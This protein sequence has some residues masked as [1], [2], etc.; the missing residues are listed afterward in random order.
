MNKSSSRRLMRLGS[1]ATISILLPVTGW[2][3]ASTDVIALDAFVVNTEADSGYLSSNTLSGNLTNTPLE[4]VPANISVINREFLDDIASDNIFDAVEF[5]TGAHNVDGPPADNNGNSIVFR[6]FQSNWQSR[7]GFQWYVPTDNYNTERVEFNRG[8]VGQLYGESAIAG[9]M[10][11]ETKR[12]LLRDQNS[13]VLR[14]DSEGSRRGSLDLNRKL[15]DNLGVRINLLGSEE[16]FWTSPAS[17]D[18]FG[19]AGA[20]QWRPYEQTRIDI[21]YEQGEINR[22]PIDGRPLD[23]FSDYTS[24]TAG[25]TS[26][27]FPAGSQVIRGAGNNQYWTLIGSSMVNLESTG[28]ANGS[29]PNATYFLRSSV[30]PN[31]LQSVSED[32]VPRDV[33]LG[34]SFGSQDRDFRTITAQAVQG[35]L[36]ELTAT[37]TYNYQWQI[38]D[39]RFA[40]TDI[41]RDLAPFYPTGNN[42]DQLVANPNFEELYVDIIPNYTTQE[43][44][45]HQ[46]RASLMYDLELPF[47]AQRILASYS[48]RDSEFFLRARSLALTSD[49]IAAAGI[50]GAAATARLNEV[51]VRYYLED[52]PPA[53]LDG[54][55]TDTEF[56]DRVHVWQDVTSQLDSYSV[57]AFGTYLDGR[58][59]TMIGVRQDDNYRDR[60]DTVFGPDGEPTL[61][62]NADGTPAYRF[63]NEVSNTSVNYGGVVR[64]L[65]WLDFFYNYGESF[66]FAGN[67]TLFTGEQR[68]P[69]QGEGFDY[70]ARL[71]FNDGKFR[72]NYTRFDN[73]ELNRAWGRPPNSVIGEINDLL[74][75]VERTYVRGNVL[76]DR[77]STGNEL[78]IVGS[79]LRNLTVRLS[80]SDYEV[81]DS[82][83]MPFMSQ[84]LDEMRDVATSPAQ[85]AETE[86]FVNNRLATPP[87]ADA[88]YNWAVRYNWNEGSLK[89]VAAGFNGFWRDE[90]ERFS[91]TAFLPALTQES[92]AVHNIF[93]SYTRKLRSELDW[94][95]QL[96]VRN[97]F[98]E[99]PRLG[100]YANQ[101]YLDPREFVLTNTFRF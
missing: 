32:V 93:V 101:Y 68:P 17:D 84:T 53:A 87:E 71:I 97:V 11:T 29:A 62:T 13:I 100:G 80:Y 79:P 48:F 96:N 55:P 1:L 6:G 5:A 35:I 77:T 39:N 2:S 15:T 18:R 45:V 67:G 8:P 89:G 94:T 88:R 22:V 46:V 47:M 26:P 28:P 56:Y 78:E 52:G 65:P 74:S 75:P 16:R 76:R 31:T 58:V 33:Q 36:P 3:Q 66:Q 4:D 98:D 61:R 38:G 30:N 20:V 82:R 69:R 91:G 99:D 92:Y 44:K 81:V 59:N 51:T 57:N 72:V 43:N 85:Y 86:A 64:T 34:G 21:F 73:T 37:L 27:P 42:P 10:N 23:R 9:I 63:I 25:T 50:T 7:D 41:H 83:L 90:V 49:A 12:A 70:G 19:V 24:G 60:R 95:V 54:I 40:N 14:F